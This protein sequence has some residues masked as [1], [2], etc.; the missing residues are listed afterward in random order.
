MKLSRPVI[1]LLVIPVVASAALGALIFGGDAI[2]DA[3]SNVE[4]DI[5]QALAKQITTSSL[6]ELRNLQE[7]QYGYGICGSY[8]AVGTQDGYA[9]FFYDAVNHKVVRDVNAQA[10]TSNCSLSAICRDSG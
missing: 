8:R 9:S 10:F 1:F 5:Q 3:S 4:A 7:V 2:S 6:F